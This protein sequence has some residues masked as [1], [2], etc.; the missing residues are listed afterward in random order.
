MALLRTP[1]CCAPRSYEAVKTP[2]PGVL[3]TASSS[4]S[5]Q[6]PEWG[7]AAGRPTCHL[8]SPH[9]LPALS[10]PPSTPARLLVTPTLVG[11]PLGHLQEEAVAVWCPV[12]GLEPLQGLHST[13]THCPHRQSVCAG[14]PVAEEELQAALESIQKLLGVHHQAEKSPVCSEASHKNGFLLCVRSALSTDN[15][16]MKVVLQGRAMGGHLV[17]LEVF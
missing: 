3:R 8:E 10:P 9:L 7:R 5:V 12:L 4:V 11:E 6:L 15:N 14:C 13:P 16:R 17:R 1:Y 2:E